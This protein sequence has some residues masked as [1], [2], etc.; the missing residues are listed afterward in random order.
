MMIARRL[1]TAASAAIAAC[2]R[3]WNARA[4]LDG[5]LDFIDRYGHLVRYLQVTPISATACGIRAATVAATS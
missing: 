4:D 3:R 2:G 5:C 1:A